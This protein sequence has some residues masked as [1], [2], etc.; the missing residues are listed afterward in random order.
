MV[1][2][3]ILESENLENTKT[4]LI[5]H[6]IRRISVNRQKMISDEVLKC[7]R[8]RDRQRPQSRW[9]YSIKYDSDLSRFE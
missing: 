3:A 5:L 8:I 9:L 2:T 6:K 1:T 4:V 7:F